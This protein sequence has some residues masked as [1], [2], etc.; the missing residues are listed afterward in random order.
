MVSG[1]P[2]E[3]L[4]DERRHDAA[5]AQPH[6]RAVGVEDADDLR[7]HAVIAVVGHRHRFGETLRLI[8]NAARSDRV[9]VAP[10]I[11]LLR[12]D[13]RIAVA[14]RSRGQEER[15]LLGFGEA[16][17]VVRAE[18]ADFQRR[19]R[20]LE[21]I[22]RAGRRGEMEDVIDFSSG[23]KMIV[24]DVVLDEGE[25]LVA[26]EVLD[27]LEVAGDEIV[28]RDDAM[29]FR[30]QPVGQMRAEKSGAAG[31]DRNLLRT[32]SHVPEF[33]IVAENC[34]EQIN[35]RE[36][37]SGRNGIRSMIAPGADT[38]IPSLQFDVER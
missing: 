15:R 18:R 37:R 35:R 28:D 8:V 26:G 12:M 22:D 2:A 24:R 7:V 14:F 31:D 30:E 36:R 11:F 1:V 19:D 9:H 17:R 6:P 21:I 33:L 29:T 5:V 4:P 34:G 23:R 25:I 10:V 3:R 20:Q 27:V 13:E 38:G 32:R 16:E